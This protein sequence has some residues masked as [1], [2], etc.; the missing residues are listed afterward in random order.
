MHA[1]IDPRAQP[2]AEKAADL[3]TQEHDAEQS[4]D[5]AQAEHPQHQLVGHRSGAQPQE[6]HDQGKGIGAR[7][8]DRHREEQQHGRHPDRVQPRQQVLDAPSSGRSTAGVG[9]EDIRQRDQG[10]RRAGLRQAQPMLQQVGGQMG[11]DEG[12]LETAGEEPQVQQPETPATHRIPDGGADRKVRHPPLC[13]PG[14]GS[15]RHGQRQTRQHKQAEDDRGVPPAR[16]GEQTLNE[17]HQAELAQSADGAGA[18]QC[19]VAQPRLENTGQGAIDGAK[20][21]A[22]QGDT[23][24][25]AVGGRETDGSPGLRHQIQAQAI[26]QD[27]EAQHLAGTVA[28][29]HQA[30][31]GLSQAP[32]EVLQGQGQPERFQGPAMA[33]GHRLHEQALRMPDSQRQAHEDSAGKDDGPAGRGSQGSIG[34]HRAAP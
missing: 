30:G 18:G 27:P 31:H 23:D 33:G 2:H 16:L 3:V 8:R 1:V 22:R 24:Q 20:G 6:T 11:R 7:R 5:V 28:V 25:H 26:R 13:F 9:A 19:P 10:Q 4:R 12:Q 17:R 32:D 14:S 29:G 15:Q 21:R 34:A